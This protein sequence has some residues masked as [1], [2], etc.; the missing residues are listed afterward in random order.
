MYRTT[1]NRC[2]ITV[3][4]PNRPPSRDT[5]EGFAPAVG[6]ASSCSGCGC[7]SIGTPHSAEFHRHGLRR[8]GPVP[9]TIKDCG[10]RRIPFARHRPSAH[11]VYRLYRLPP[12]SSGC[13]SLKSST[14]AS[15]SKD[16]QTTMSTSPLLRSLP[17]KALLSLCQ[18]RYSLSQGSSE[19]T[20][21]WVLPW[22]TMEPS[23]STRKRVVSSI[24]PSGIGSILLASLFQRCVAR[25]KASWMR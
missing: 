14:A 9:K 5:A 12:N 1:V 24:P 7:F 25:V 17:L 21:S 3:P 8:H 13:R 22:K 23:L 2:A 4:G 19:W 11:R 16:D 10:R 15:S 18:A 20:R 6:P